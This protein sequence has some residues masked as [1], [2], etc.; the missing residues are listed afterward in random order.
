MYI[1]KQLYT[2]KKDNDN[3]LHRSDI[4][5]PSQGLGEKYENVTSLISELTEYKVENVNS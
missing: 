5:E 4:Q 2:T 1:C 3:H